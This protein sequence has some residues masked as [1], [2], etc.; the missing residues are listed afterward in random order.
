MDQDTKVLISKIQQAIWKL[1][2]AK[3]LL[4]EIDGMDFH[5][6]SL[7]QQ[8]DF[9]EQEMTELYSLETK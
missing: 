3:T 1:K 7:T 9:L 4:L 5:T 8:I 2:Q 6:D